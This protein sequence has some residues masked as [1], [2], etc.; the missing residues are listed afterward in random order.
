M[1]KKVSL[2]CCILAA[3]IAVVPLAACNNNPTAAPQS[4]AESD[5][6]TE[7][8]GCSD[9]Y[10]GSVSEKTYKEEGDAAEA[11]VRNEI[12]GADEQMQVT[13]N[14]AQSVTKE[15]AEKII[16]AEFTKDAV[17]FK[18]AEVTYGDTAETSTQA[19]SLSAAKTDNKDQSQKV[20][21]SKKVVVYL[22]KYGEEWKYFTPKVEVGNR[23]T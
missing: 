13:V 5:L 12:L 15:E 9:T 17:E 4:K 16:P 2:V 6:I 7:I 11:F 20:A 1:K 8:G 23:I 22:I 21:Q 3:I 18:K 10:A 19:I 14:K